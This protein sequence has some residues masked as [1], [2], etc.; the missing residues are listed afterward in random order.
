MQEIPQ[1]SL[2]KEDLLAV[3]LPPPH[4]GGGEGDLVVQ[5]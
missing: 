4:V 3:Q 5:M 1:V 2:S